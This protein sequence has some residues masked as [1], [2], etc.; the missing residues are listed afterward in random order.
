MSEY[1]LIH[2]DNPQHR[3]IAKA[4]EIVHKG[5]VIVYPTDSSYAIGC[6][7]GNK[8]GAERIRRIRQLDKDHNFTLMC[9]DLSDIS[10]YSRV[11]NINYRLLKAQTPGAY[12]FI[13]PATGE[14]PRR[15]Q[16]PRRRTIGLRIPDNLIAQALL[17]ELGEPLMSSTLIMPDEDFPMTDP[18]QIRLQLEHHVD[19][20][21]DGGYSGHQPTTV[22]DLTDD[23]PV[24]LR[25]GKGDVDW[26]VR[27]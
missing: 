4:V 6:L 22:I 16:N 13:L 26:L 9:R 2:P 1:F 15:L 11:D 3:L 7:L 12:T 8:R 18:Y 5:G 17:A 24:L 20:I 27:H 23:E 19:L 25:E 14:V 10:Q 21:I